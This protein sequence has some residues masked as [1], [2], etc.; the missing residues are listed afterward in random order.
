LRAPA[1]G[2]ER[3]VFSGEVVAVSDIRY[4]AD[5]REYLFDV[6]LRSRVGLLFERERVKAAIN[7]EYLNGPDMGENFLRDGLGLW[8]SYLRGGTEYSHIQMGVYVEDWGASYSRG[9]SS[10][11]NERDERYPDNVFFSKYYRPNPL[12]SMT[13]GKESLYTQAALSNR[14]MPVESIEDSD[15][16][17]RGV[18]K[19]GTVRTTG[20]VIKN[21][22]SS[23]IL[24][25][26]T[27]EQEAAEGRQWLE[28]DWQYLP[29]EEDVWSVALGFSRGLSFSRIAAEYLLLDTEDVLFLEQDLRISEVLG[30]DLKL[31]VHFPDFS[32]ALS[33]FFTLNVGGG[34][35]FEPGVYG[36]IGRRGDYFSPTVPENDNRAVIRLRFQF[37]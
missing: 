3:P 19:S 7:V 15:F 21:I 2:G 33:G 24:S 36:F 29:S 28:V 1:G 25:F 8:E 31:Y 12:F 23:S 10:V 17:L 34:L 30:F 37:G 11:L 5:Q 9:L 13:M 14:E 22:G 35:T 16:G 4:A 6:W 32:T 26:A 27:L 20:G 18:V